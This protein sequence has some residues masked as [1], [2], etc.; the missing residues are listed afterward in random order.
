MH[1]LVFLAMI[2]ALVGANLITR[3]FLASPDFRDLPTM[4]SDN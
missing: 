2:A 4:L 1:E 3:R